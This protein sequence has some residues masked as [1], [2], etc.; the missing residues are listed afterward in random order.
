MI[1][2]FV[3]IFE[4][5]LF[6]ICSITLSESEDQVVSCGF[7]SFRPKCLQRFATIQAFVFFCCILVT[8]QQALSSGYFNRFDRFVWFGIN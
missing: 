1:T 4:W 2:I 8:L 6:L 7:M 3:L 5:I